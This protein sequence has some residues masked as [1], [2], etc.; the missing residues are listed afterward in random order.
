MTRLIPGQRGETRLGGVALVT[1]GASGLGRCIVERFLSDGLRV[2]VISRDPTKLPIENNAFLLKLKA[3]LTN[4]Q[5]VKRAVLSVKG[6][7]GSPIAILVNNAGVS[8]PVQPISET[9]LEEWNE[10]LAVNL[11]GAFL[12]CKYV[13]PIMVEAGKGGRIINIS[14]MVGKKP[15]PFRAAYSASKMGLLGLT[16]SLSSELAKYGI[17]VNAVCPGPLEGTRI[18][19]IMRKTAGV[20]GTDVDTV[21]QRLIGSSSLGRLTKPQEVA[22]LVSFLVSEEAYAIT[23]QDLSIDSGSGY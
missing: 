15:V 12:C 13:V 5:Q 14:S 16:R 3:N 7:F 20:G 6:Q 19:D 11:T 17:T 22:A 21:R 18:E 10:T 23:G 9:S 2:A 4:P 1:G 8:G